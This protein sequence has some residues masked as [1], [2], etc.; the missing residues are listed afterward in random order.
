MGTSQTPLK[1]CGWTT[2]PRGFE[3]ADRNQNRICMDIT[4]HDAHRIVICVNALDG[5]PDWEIEQFTENGINDLSSIFAARQRMLTDEN[6]E[7]KRAL[8]IAHTLVS[9]E[10]ELI[11]RNN[12]TRNQFRT[13][14]RVLGINSIVL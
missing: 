12:T 4:K 3:I 7:L 9:S 5:F 10:R 1:V 8:Y 14:E 13:I 11:T 2:G 6:R